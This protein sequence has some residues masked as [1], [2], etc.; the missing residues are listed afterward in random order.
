MFLEIN[1]D[2]G[3]LL[4]I[5][6]DSTEAT[7]SL[8]YNQN[9]NVFTT[10]VVIPDFDVE[11]GIKLSVTDSDAKGKKMHGITI[12]VTNRNIPQLTLV[13]HTR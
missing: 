8:K 11:A 9:K 1:T 7:A 4:L 5:G 12:D 6:D 2:K 10:E 13:G 3:F